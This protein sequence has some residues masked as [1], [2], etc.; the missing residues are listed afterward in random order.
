M[1]FSTLSTLALAAPALASPISKRWTCGS[2]NNADCSLA[3]L[4]ERAGKL[5]FGTA[6]QSFYLAV[7][8][9]SKILT[10]EFQ[11]Y[12]PENEMKW[13]VIQPTRGVYNWTGADLVSEF[14]GCAE[15]RSSP[16]RRRRRLWSE[17]TTLS[18]T[19]RR[20]LTA[21]SQLMSALHT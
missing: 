4:A 19:N 14:E 5:Y 18:G 20:E 13:E 2:S 1:L 17:V 6:W 21:L 10:S 11:Q 3:S 7:P 15:T 12:T 8:E 9:F 16:K